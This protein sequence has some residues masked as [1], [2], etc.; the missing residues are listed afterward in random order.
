MRVWGVI[1]G[2]ECITARGR[3]WG[4][5]IFGMEWG[6]LVE[7]EGLYDG[8]EKLFER[9]KM[10]YERGELKFREVYNGEGEA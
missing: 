8:D 7:E 5:S 3:S 1:Y 10:I 2:V 6:G 9:R 4:I